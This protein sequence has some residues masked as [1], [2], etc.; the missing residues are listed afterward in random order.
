[1]SIHDYQ[2]ADQAGV[3]FLSDLNSMAGAI[4]SN[5]SSAT[6][7]STTYAYQWWADTTAG[8]L[9]LRNAANSAWIETIGLDGTFDGRDVATDGTKLDGLGAQN[10]KLNTKVIDIGAWDMPAGNKSVS[11]GLAF[12]KIRTVDVMVLEDESIGTAMYPLNTSD[13][14]GVRGAF[15]ISS[16]TIGLIAFSGGSFNS[17]NFNSTTAPSNRGWITIQYID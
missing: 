11:H 1:M 7:P 6:Q 9:K 16:S 2:I 17:T 8:I 3:A 15:V 13:A 5:N 4:V 10:V 14:G 12:S